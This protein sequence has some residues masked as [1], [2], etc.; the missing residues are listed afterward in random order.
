M[1]SLNNLV[2]TLICQARLQNAA[3]ARHWF[4]THLDKAF[5]LLTTP[6]SVL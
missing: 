2:L 3:Q 6:F 5:V 4:A 1:A